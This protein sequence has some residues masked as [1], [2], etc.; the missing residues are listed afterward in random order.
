MSVFVNYDGPNLGKSQKRMVR[1]QAMISVRDQQRQAKKIA[2]VAALPRQL[3]PTRDSSTKTPVAP[4]TGQKRAQLLLAGK[5]NQILLARRQQK[6]N[7]W[8]KLNP[9]D[10]RGAPPQSTHMTGVPARTFQDYLSR[11]GSYSSYLDEAFILVPGFRQPSY[12]RPDLSKAACI[13]IG[14]LLTASVL[15]AL[16]GK[17][18]AYPWYEYQAVKELKGFVESGGTM[19]VYEV[20]YPVIILGIFELVRFSPHAATHLAAVENI[21][22]SRGGLSTMPEVM[23]HLVIMTDMLECICLNTPLAFNELGPNPVVRLNTPEDF[24]SGDQ[25]RS[26][27]L[28]LCDEEDF[29]FAAQYVEPDIRTDLISVLG[30]ASNTFLAL[31]ES[32]TPT[33]E[34]SGESDFDLDVIADV[35]TVSTKV[36][37]LFL[38][39]CALATRITHR[40]TTGEANAF[41]DPINHMDAKTMYY[42]L[43]FM[44]L[45][46]WAGLPYVYVWVNLVGFAA[47]R[48]DK[49]RM[50]FFPELVRSAY[51]YGCY[52]LL[53][54]RTVL[55][56]FIHLQNAIRARKTR[57]KLV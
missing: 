13:Y 31:F 42:N 24:P 40:T 33:L 28:L 45:K 54:F 18:V 52:Q 34:N 36:S 7:P 30:A 22:K 6:L 51:S 47:A 3:L 16:S 53:V 17:E 9:W 10:M 50:Y 25:L 29:S 57:L 15:D 48:D 23:Q 38:Q 1:S 43:R 32:K 19:E 46:V 20:V 26:C 27:P 37:G 5:Q 8:E 44:G 35:T 12:F 2:D 39:T 4:N 56:N 11:C 55:G 49:M 21:I 14:W 41:D